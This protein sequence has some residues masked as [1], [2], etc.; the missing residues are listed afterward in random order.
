VLGGAVAL[1]VGCPAAPSLTWSNPQFANMGFSFGYDGTLNLSQGGVKLFGFMDEGGYGTGI[2]PI[3]YFSGSNRGTIESST[4]LVL[5]ALSNHFELEGGPTS[6][7]SANIEIVPYKGG[8]T[9]GV[10]LNF[11]TDGGS[12]ANWTVAVQ[13]SSSGN[14]ATQIFQI[15]NNSQTMV[16]SFDGLGNVFCNGQTVAN[17]LGG[18][19]GVL[20]IAS[21]TTAPT[22]NP[23]GGGI[24]YVDT[25]ALKYR[26]SSGTV[27]TLAAA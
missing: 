26:G 27:T 14:N 24:L 12:P 1:P 16:T 6:G 19:Q 3:I 7:Q 22:T 5:R 13:G 10:P 8:T 17:G 15:Q 9:T 18:G 4:A 25:G 11:R 20:A 21:A 23:T 2:G